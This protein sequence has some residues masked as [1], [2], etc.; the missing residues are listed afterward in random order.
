MIKFKKESTEVIYNSDKLLTLNRKDIK[1]L[2]KN[3]L[4][5]KKKI[6]RLCAHKNI[7][8]KIH[9]MFIVH[10][11]NYFV[12]PH[13]HNNE[14]SMFVLKGSVDI[15]LFNK[16]GKINKVIRMGD[17]YSNKIFY[18]KLPKNTFHTLIINSIKLIFYEVTKGPFSRKNFKKA[19]FFGNFAN[20]D[21]NKKKQFIS[22]IKKEIKNKKI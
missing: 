16:V 10:P 18:Y 13:K 17:Y 7:K 11:K 12:H 4:F 1:A 22:N 19:S 2:V 21:I 6:F 9:Q 20:N 5:S 14:E 8:D 15:V 3:S